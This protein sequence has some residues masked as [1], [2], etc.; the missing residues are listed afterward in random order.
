MIVENYWSDKAK[1]RCKWKE[2]SENGLNFESIHFHTKV[3]ACSLQSQFQYDI[4]DHMHRY[5]LLINIAVEYYSRKFDGRVNNYFQSDV[6]SL[7]NRQ[8]L[9]HWPILYPMA[10]VRRDLSSN[11]LV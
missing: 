6:I 8:I 11:E 7:P 3:V 2:Q 9:G 10:N 5:S 1:K 4:E